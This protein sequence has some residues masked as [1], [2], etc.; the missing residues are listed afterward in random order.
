MAKSKTTVDKGP[1]GS[2]ERV[3]MTVTG[4]GKETDWFSLINDLLRFISAII[5]AKSSDPD[6]KRR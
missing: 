1:D 2:T 6:R 5:E 4:N 3:T